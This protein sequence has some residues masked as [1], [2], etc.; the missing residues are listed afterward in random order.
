MS[1]VGVYVAALYDYGCRR[2]RAGI[3]EEILEMF[4]YLRGK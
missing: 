4:S 3:W 1:L 2:S